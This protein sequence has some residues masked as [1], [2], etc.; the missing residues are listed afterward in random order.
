MGLGHR[1]TLFC[2]IFI[3]TPLL[4]F[5]VFLNNKEAASVLKSR[6]RRANSFF[7]EFKAPSLERECIE[8]TCS[9]E[10][11]REIFKDERRLKAFWSTYTD[12]N[13]CLSNPCLNG[14][15]CSDQFQL[16][17]CTCPE[18]Y[19]GR[20][21]ETNV[22]ESTTCENANGQCDQFCHSSVEGHRRCVC[23]EG[24]ALGEDGISC[25]PTVNYPCGQIPVL[26]KKKTLF[27]IVGGEVCPKGECPWQARLVLP[28]N[29]DYLC[30]GTLIAP[31][32][33]ITAAHCVKPNFVDK[34][35]AVLGDHKISAYEGTEQERKVVEI[36]IHKGYSKI[37]GNYDHDIALLRLNASVNY[38]D[39]V[40]PMCLPETQFAVR[41]LLHLSSSSTVSGWGRLLDGGATPDILRRVRLPRI[42]SQQCREQ[43][44]LNITENMFCAG[45]TDG[46]KDACK[47]D[48]GGPY[49]TKYKGTYYLTGIVS[50]GLGCA[51]V[52]KY[53]VYARVSR[54]TTWINKHMNQTTT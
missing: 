34:L 16:Y 38:T 27:R 20:N 43:T 51:K 37:K 12:A 26:K 15:I 3:L 9:Y 5:A 53:G 1:E 35:S 39:Y 44:G 2:F 4:T 40:V 24:Y 48:S 46:S 49:I 29:I 21:C 13:D 47:G 11:A 42:M 36:I 17:V 28:K 23:M 19:E 8:E 18:G 50:W 33:V 31:N 7:E 10:E 22:E 14:G 45:Y 6:V 52:D 54:Y 25:I 41:V 32:W 30:G